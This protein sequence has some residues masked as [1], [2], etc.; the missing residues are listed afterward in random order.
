MKLLPRPWVKVLVLPLYNILEFRGG[1]KEIIVE[2]FESDDEDVAKMSRR[3]IFHELKSSNLPPP[4]LELQ[5]V[6]NEANIIVGA[7]AETTA[8]TL[9]LLT[10]YM[11]TNREVLRKLRSELAGK[12]LKWGLLASRD[13][14]IPRLEQLPYI[15]RLLLMYTSPLVNIEQSLL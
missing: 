5:R 1:V 11:A 6:A 13:K 14:I 15:V 12:P 3:T 9:T 7:G 4:E 10:Y 2:V 8:R